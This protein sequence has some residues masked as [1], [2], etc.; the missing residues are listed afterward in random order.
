MYVVDVVEI[1]KI[2]WSQ[3]SNDHA[4]AVNCEETFSL[5][6]TSSLKKFLC[7]LVTI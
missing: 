5:G 4:N 2:G 7:G 6:L 3:N 1:S